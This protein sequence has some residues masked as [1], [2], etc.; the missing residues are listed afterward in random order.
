M[1]ARSAI[2]QIALQERP[3]CTVKNLSPR[4][5]RLD[6]SPTRPFCAVT[7]SSQSLARFIVLCRSKVACTSHDVGLPKAPAGWLYLFPWPESEM[8]GS[9]K[10]CNDLVDVEPNKTRPDL[11]VRNWIRLGEDLARC[12]FACPAFSRAERF[13]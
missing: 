4:G 11:K 13:C 2:E 1:G 10:P 12:L 6:V 7:R 3:F 5:D 8:L 9:T